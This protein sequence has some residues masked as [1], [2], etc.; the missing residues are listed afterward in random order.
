MG[1][2][3]HKF[4]V[5]IIGS[6][7]GSLSC[8]SILAQLQKKKVLILERHFKIGGFT[9]TFR[10]KG[11]YEWDVGVHYVGEMQKGHIFRKIFDFVTQNKVKWNRMPDAYDIFVYPGLKFSARA[12]RDNFKQDLID[13]FPNEETAIE[14]YFRDIQKAVHW[15]YRYCVAK[16]LPAWLSIVSKFLVSPAGHLAL[17]TVED[18][19]NSRIQ[20]QKLKAV[21]AFQW[22]TIGLP[23]SK[24]A[25]TIHALIVNHYIEGAY[26]P[27]GGAKVIADSIIPIIENH[28]GK[29]LVNHEVKEILIQDG[30]ATGVKVAHK[31]GKK[32]IEKEYTADVI[33]SGIGANATYNRLIPPEINIPFREECR[34]LARGTSCVTL[35]LGL[36]DTPETI[37]LHGGN[38]WLFSSFDHENIFSERNRIIQGDV[39]HIYLSFPSLKNLKSRAHTAEIITFMDHEPFKQWAD[40]PWLNRDQTYQDLKDS[41]AEALIDFTENHIKGFKE[42]IDYKELATPLTTEFMTGHEKGDIYGMP[43]TPER[44]KAK[45]PGART[46]IQNLYLTGADTLV[47][48]VVGGLLGGTLTAGIVMG[49]PS[50]ILKILKNNQTMEVIRC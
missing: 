21:L 4:D 23:P 29:L 41:M 43:V 47:H 11:K 17:M 44:Y 34:K 39:S 9:H 7:I 3:D 48:G 30:K 15:F 27:V 14:Q 13:Q 46:P 6:G 40:Q 36:R 28:G 31:K 2:D 16:S 32:Y 42:L 26:Y 1:I 45:W 35:Y 37:G 33:I 5:I 10:R 19:L 22:G 20:D 18:Y 50:G 38:Y 8:A 12:G 24:S 25:F 49:I